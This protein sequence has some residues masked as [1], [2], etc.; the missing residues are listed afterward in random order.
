M[1]VS[2][3]NG[4]GGFVVGFLKLLCTY[5]NMSLTKFY[6]KMDQLWV[7]GNVKWNEKIEKTQKNNHI[8]YNNLNGSTR[9]STFISEDNR[10]LPL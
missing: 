5:M 2:L 9:V 7:N 6:D 8:E 3:D 10:K 1:E 4:E